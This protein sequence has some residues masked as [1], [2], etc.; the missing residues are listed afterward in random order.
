[1]LS[2]QVL[3]R[4]GQNSEVLGTN[5]DSPGFFEP[6]FDWEKKEVDVQETC[7]GAVC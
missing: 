2:Q 6:D 4:F 1:V 7:G 3:I 5:V